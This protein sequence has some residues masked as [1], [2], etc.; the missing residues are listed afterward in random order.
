VEAC[1]LLAGAIALAAVAVVHGTH[2]SRSAAAALSALPT[3]LPVRTSAALASLIVRSIL[4]LG[5]T[6]ITSAAPRLTVVARLLRLVYS[7]IHSYTC[8]LW[9]ICRMSKG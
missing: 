2:K 4:A 1:A 8:E 3:V 7:F 6:K 9:S 5:A